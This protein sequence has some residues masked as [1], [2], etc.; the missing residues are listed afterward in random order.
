[1]NPTL[2]A[3]ALKGE[4]MRFWVASRSKPDWHLVDMSLRLGNGTCDCR[5]YDFCAYPNWKRHQRFVPYEYDPETWKCGNSHEASE[6][7]HIRAARE[8][9]HREFVMPIYA[10]QAQGELEWF[11]RLARGV[12]PPP[13]ARGSATV[14]RSP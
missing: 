13:P 6:C 5:M 1:M 2:E 14:P 12:S 3:K 8:L 10:L 9:L 4:K 11:S 7:A